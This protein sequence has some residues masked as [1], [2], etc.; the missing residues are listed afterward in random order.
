VKL[1]YSEYEDRV[2][3]AWVGQILGTLMGFQFEH[4]TSSVENVVTLPPKYQSAP[5][6]DDYYYEPVAL[7]AFEKH[8]TG[9]TVEQLGEQWKV[10][11]AGA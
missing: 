7:R 10:N 11:N 6:D 8:G 2:H 3:A 1:P 5:V 4:K 9:L